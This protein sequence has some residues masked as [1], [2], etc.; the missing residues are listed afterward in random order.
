MND[1]RKEIAKNKTLASSIEFFNSDKPM[2]L[3]AGFSGDKLPFIASAS[4]EFIPIAV[5]FCIFSLTSFHLL[6]S[7]SAT[8]SSS[9]PLIIKKKTLKRQ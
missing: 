3:S 8:L 1:R 7:S 6:S 5:S 9:S 2:A 4:E